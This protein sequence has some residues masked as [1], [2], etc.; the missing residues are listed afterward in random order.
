MQKKETQAA[1]IHVSAGDTGIQDTPVGRKHRPRDHMYMKETRAN[2][3]H[4]LSGNTAD[5]TNV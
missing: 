2:R 5:R 1:R 4:V 3:T